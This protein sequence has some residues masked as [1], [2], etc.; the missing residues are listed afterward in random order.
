MATEFYASQ[1]FQ[2]AKGHEVATLEPRNPFRAPAYAKAMQAL[3]TQPWLFYLEEGGSITCGCLGFLRAGRLERSLEIPSVPGLPSDDTFWSGLFSFCRQQRITRLSTESFG[4][5]NTAIPH[6]AAEID[7]RTRIEYVLDLRDPDL[8]SNVSSN[9]RRNIRKAQR[10]SVVLERGAATDVCFEHAR[11]QDASMERRLSRGEQVTADA[12]TRAFVSFVENAAGEIFR[13]RL[14]GRVL[15]S[16]LVLRA[17]RGAYYHSAGTSPEGMEVG[18]SHFL[19]KQVVEFLR[20]EGHEEFNLGGADASNPGLERFKAGFGAR[21]VNLE[22]A[23]FYLGSRLQKGIGALVS[24][25]R[26]FSTPE[27]P[28]KGSRKLSADQ[29]TTKS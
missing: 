27:P 10:A 21:L 2:T 4:S 11:L 12:K 29:E 14:G 7:R 6:V 25:C 17:A 18:A 13:A 26:R 15:S 23:E 28:S 19:I 8:W 9:H 24:L 3:G 16:I 1:D 20:T 22:A 5:C